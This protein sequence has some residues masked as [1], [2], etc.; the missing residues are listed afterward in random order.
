[1]VLSTNDATPRGRPSV[2][3]VAEIVAAAGLCVD[4]GLDVPAAVMAVVWPQTMAEEWWIWL[5]V[6]LR[7]VAV[8]ALAARRIR[9]VQTVAGGLLVLAI[10]TLLARPTVSNALWQGASGAGAAA[11]FVAELAVVLALFVWAWHA[12]RARPPGGRWAD[13]WLPLLLIPIPAGLTWLALGRVL[14]SWLILG[15]R[16]FSWCYPLL[17]VPLWLAGRLWGRV[18]PAG[19]SP[20]T[21]MLAVAVLIA[22]WGPL[23]ALRAYQNT[24]YENTQGLPGS[25][26]S[27]LVAALANGVVLLAIA[28]ISARRGLREARALPA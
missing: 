4:L 28:V 11:A 18:G 24:A 27:P 8:A 16:S 15:D 3:E 2:S 17:I 10:A 6:V 25:Y 21:R 5:G 1:M 19:T 9:L 13:A 12:P 22:A 20:A 26:G 7:C 23:M 14:P